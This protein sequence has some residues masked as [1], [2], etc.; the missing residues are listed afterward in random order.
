[1]S[2]YL[3]DEQ[4]PWPDYTSGT[5]GSTSRNQPKNINISQRNRKIDSEDKLVKYIRTQLGEPLITVDVTDTQIRYCIDDCFKKFTDWAYDS[6]QHMA[7]V[8]EMQSGIQDYIL[9]DRVKAIYDMSI[10]DTTTSYADFASGGIS[11]GGFG[12]VPIGY[13]PYV[14]PMG[15]VSSLSRNGLGGAGFQG[16]ATGVAGGVAGP[17]SGGGS[18]GDAMEAAWAAMANAQTMQNLFGKSV[19]YDFNSQ[20]HILRIF[21]DFA[22]PVLIEAA[23]EYIPNADHDDIYG[24]SWIKEYALNLTKNVWGSNV[25]K[26]SSSLVGGSDINYDRLLSESETALDRLNE[27]LLEKWSEALGIFSG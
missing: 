17:N 12:M 10:A 24:H 23:L 13:V 20:N 5:D 21:E 19:S 2:T 22:G 1:M 25:G 16:T 7:F 3:S 27:D 4:S 18:P 6:T 15:N 11:L 8:I 26:Y 14:D 9:D